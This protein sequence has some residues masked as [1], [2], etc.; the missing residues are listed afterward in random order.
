MAIELFGWAVEDGRSK[1]MQWSI[2]YCPA[3]TTNL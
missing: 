1:A 3:T 2:G